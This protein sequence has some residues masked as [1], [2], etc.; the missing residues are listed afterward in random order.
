MQDWKM[1]DRRNHGGRKCKTGKRSHT[2]LSNVLP[3]THL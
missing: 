1:T 3:A 2:V